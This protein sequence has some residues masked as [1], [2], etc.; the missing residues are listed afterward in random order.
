MRKR[1]V[2][3]RSIKDFLAYLSGRI[4]EELHC[5]WCKKR[6]VISEATVDHVIDRADGGR[7]HISNCVIACKDCNLARGRLTHLFRRN[8]R[9]R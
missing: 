4:G 1:R 7:H 8:K 2:A 9:R 3:N 5:H 6:L